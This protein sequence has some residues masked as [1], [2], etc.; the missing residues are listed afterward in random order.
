VKHVLVT[1]TLSPFKLL[2]AIA[3][4]STFNCREG[5]FFPFLLLF[6]AQARG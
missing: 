4:T 3:S 1:L 6:L 5:I 2:F